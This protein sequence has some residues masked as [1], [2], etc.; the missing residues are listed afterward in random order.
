MPHDFERQRK[1]TEWAWNDINARAPIPR[2]IDL[3]IQFVEDDG[4]GNWNDCEKAL[5]LAGYKTNI[6]DDGSTLEVN[7]PSTDGQLEN[8]WHHEERTTQ[9]ALRYGFRPDGWGFLRE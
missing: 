8:I 5:R 2:L 7:V 9:I 6:Y 4:S 3:D 1:E